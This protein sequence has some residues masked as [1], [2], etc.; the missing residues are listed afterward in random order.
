MR[1]FSSKN[2]RIDPATGR[3]RRDNTR[4]ATHGGPQRHNGKVV[5]KGRLEHQ[6]A[7]ATGTAPRRRSWWS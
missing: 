5:P 3:N 1:L 6:R 7:R 4:R 2:S